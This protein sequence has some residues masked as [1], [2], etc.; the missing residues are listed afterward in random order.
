[1]KF[2]RP[3]PLPVPAANSI[4]SFSYLLHLESVDA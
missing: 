3:L 4:R 2:P 1:M